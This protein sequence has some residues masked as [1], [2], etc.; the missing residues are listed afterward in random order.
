MP[1]E[2]PNFATATDNDMKRYLQELWMWPDI[3]DMDRNM[4]NIE[5]A[6]R[7]LIRRGHKDY[8]DY[9]RDIGPK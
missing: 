2:R 1:V 8:V 3:N 6:E 9:L 5:D 7:E 4:R